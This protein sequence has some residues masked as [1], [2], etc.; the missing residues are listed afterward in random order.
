MASISP[1]VFVL[2]GGIKGWALAG[3]Q[4]THFMDVYVPS[5]WMQFS[6]Q[7]TGIKRGTLENEGDASTKRSREEEPAQKSEPAPQQQ[8][9][10]DMVF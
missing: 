4:Y 1:Q 3:E 2:N 5:Y 8:D 7:R 9:S 10:G 6:D